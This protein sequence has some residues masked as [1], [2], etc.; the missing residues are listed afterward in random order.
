VPLVGA[1]R[2]DRLHEALARPASELDPDDLAAVE[3]AVPVGAAAG[4]RYAEPQMAQLDSE[5]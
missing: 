2:R 3:R 1:R 5:R 4:S